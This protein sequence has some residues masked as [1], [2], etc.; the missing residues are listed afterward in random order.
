[1]LADEQPGPEQIAALKAMAGE[2]RLRIA[3][4]L[5]WT[6]RKLK[7]AGV[8]AQHPEWPEERVQEEVRRIFLHPP[9]ESIV[10]RKQA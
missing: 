2:Q 7:A 8:R 9:D 6:A 1:M 4:S 10:F 5:Y 3:E